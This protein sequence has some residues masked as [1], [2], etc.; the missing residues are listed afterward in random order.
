MGI[1][2]VDEL[3][4]KYAAKWKEEI[5]SMREMI[6]ASLVMTAQ[7]PA[8]TFNES[9]R[10]GFILERLIEAGVNEPMI[11]EIGNVI[12]VIKGKSPKR[13]ILLSAHL[14]TLFDGT[15]DHNVTITRNRAEGT[16]VADNALGVT[17]LVTLPDIIKK[18]GLELDSDIILLGTVASKEIGDLTGIRHFM[19]NFSHEIDYNINIE[20]ISLGQVD[21]SALSRV[22]CDIK[23]SLEP[24]R[25]SSWRDLGHSS[26]IMMLS[27]IL[28]NLFRIPLPHKP[29]TVMNVGR[30]QGGHSYSRVCGNAS[31]HLE[32]RSED[33]SITEKLIDEI[34]DS[35]YEV[36]AKYGDDIDLNFFSR[37]HAAGIKYSHPLVSTASTIVKK[38]GIKPKMGPSN[39]EIAVPLSLGVPSI[40][41]GLAAGS[42]D[43]SH[44]KSYV[45]LDTI[46]DGIVQTL[47]LITSIDKGYCDDDN[48]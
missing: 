4:E 29:K 3:Y 26:A 5:V 21:H 39:S 11:D 46:P 6:I 2:A 28:E 31:L 42:E 19:K 30:I 18:L 14:D 36:G 25:T 44:R 13:K 17:L 35:C 9:A 48:Q 43:K 41:I 27:D 1:Q 37:H 38:L 22:R 45:E 7:I 34:R 23:C 32:V 24:E 16:A 47:L 8:K 15:L 12:A 20:G 10:A 40:T 33:D